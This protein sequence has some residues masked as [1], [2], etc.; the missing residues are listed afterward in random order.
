[1]VVSRAGAEAREIDTHEKTVQEKLFH[2]SMEVAVLY[3]SS[4]PACIFAGG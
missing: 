1:M 4:C 2:G 3:S